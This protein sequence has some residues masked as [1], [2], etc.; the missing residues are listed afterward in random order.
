MKVAIIDYGMGNILSVARAV[1]RCGAEPVLVST[2][3][4]LEG[5]ERVILPGVGAFP[6]GMA[7]L[8]RRGLVGPLRDYADSGR[9]LMGICLGMQ[10]LFDRSYEFEETRGLGIIEGD[11]VKLNAAR[12]PNIGWLP[13]WPS[14]ENPSPYLC[15]SG[16]RF[17]FLHS[18]AA[19]TDAEVAHAEHE[20]ETFCAAV[21]RGNV[22]GTQ[23]HPEKSGPLGLRVLNRFITQAGT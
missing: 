10:M 23:F 6:S 2:P 15:E 14:P 12:L 18:Y 19:E 7:E 20:G 11:V 16:A 17:Y 22:F 4:G 8:D 21:Q 13:V 3:E 1:E 9:H 5:A